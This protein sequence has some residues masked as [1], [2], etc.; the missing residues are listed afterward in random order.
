MMLRTPWTAPSRSVLSRSPSYLEA[1]ARRLFR[2]AGLPEPVVELTW[3]THGQFRLDFA[4][5]QYGL[6]VEVD[7]WDCHSSPRSRTYDLHRRNQIVLGDLR[8]LVYTYG[9]IVRAGDRVIRE[10]REA[11][12]LRRPAA[13]HVS[14][15]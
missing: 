7:G 6:V 5:P 1:K 12:A 11:M 2:R 9:D 13:E 4:W 14:V 10:I 15:Y 8:P 3:G